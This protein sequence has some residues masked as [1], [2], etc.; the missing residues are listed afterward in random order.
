MKLRIR[1]PFYFIED[2]WTSI[3]CFHCGRKFVMYIPSIRVY[4]YCLECE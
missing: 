4:N 1:N 2:D 3:N